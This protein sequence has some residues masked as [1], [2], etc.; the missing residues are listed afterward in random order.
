MREHGLRLP[1]LG[2][3][4]RVQG[5]GLLP[6]DQHVEVKDGHDAPL[7]YNGNEEEEK[8]NLAVQQLHPELH[9]WFISNQ[10]KAVEDMDF[11]V[12]MNNIYHSNLFQKDS[13]F[14][15]HRSKAIISKTMEAESNRNSF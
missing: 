3:L 12:Q 6:F 8:H 9:T 4:E 13:G 10:E 14:I 1:L 5:V 7:D 15:A 2:L 11:V